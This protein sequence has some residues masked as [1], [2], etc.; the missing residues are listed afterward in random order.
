MRLLVYAVCGVSAFLLLGGC[1]SVA[2]FM[3]AVEPALDQAAQFGANSAGEAVKEA[4][5][6]KWGGG[7][8]AG[9]TVTAIMG[10]YAAIKGGVYAWNRKP[11]ED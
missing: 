7:E 4:M 10:A 2:D 11:K 6:G 9:A 1:A 5:R 3:R 8:I